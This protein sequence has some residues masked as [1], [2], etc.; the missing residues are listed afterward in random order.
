MLYE[1][2]ILSMNDMNNSCN[3]WLIIYI[4]AHGRYIRCVNSNY[5]DISG[6]IPEKPGYI[7]ACTRKELVS[8]R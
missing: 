5:V 2:P 8:E 7:I 4:A 1:R 6:L 3:I